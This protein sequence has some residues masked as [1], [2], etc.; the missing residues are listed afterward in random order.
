M[1]QQQSQTRIR[2]SPSVSAKLLM[3]MVG[4]LLA[5]IIFLNLSA[6]LLLKADKRAYTYQAQGT[7]ALLIGRDIVNTATHAIDTLKLSLGAINPD[8]AVTPQQIKAVDLV[9]ANQTGVLAVQLQSVNLETLAVTS[10]AES[11]NAEALQPLEMKPDELEFSDSALRSALPSLKTAGVAFFNASKLGKPA[12]LGIVL[13][14]RKFLDDPHG[15]PI[16]VGYVALNGLGREARAADIAIR[17]RAGETLFDSDPSHQFIQGRVAEDPLF[18]AAW[19]NQLASGTQEFEYKEQRYLG[20]YV[21]PG[22]DLVVL[23]RTTWRKAMAATYALTERFILLG[24]MAIGVAILFGV[25]F[26]KTLTAPINRLFRATQLVGQG[27]FE[28]SLQSESGDEIGELTRSFVAMS[29]RIGELVVEQMRKVQLENELAIASTVQESLIP[30]DRVESKHLT[31]HSHYQSASECGGDWWGYFEVGDKLCLMIAD[32]TGHGLP[33]ALITA[34]ARSCMSVLHKLGQDEAAFTFSPAAMLTY[35]SRAIHESA[36]G[37]IMMTFFAAVIDFENSTMTFSSAGHNPPWLFK[38]KGDKF[39]LKSLVADG[40]RLGEAMDVATP[41]EEKTVPLDADDVL[42]LYTDGL[43][44]G[45]S[46][47]GEQYGKKRTRKMVEANL[48]AG[49]EVMLKELM[50]DFMAFNTD[51]P[52]DDDVTLVATRIHGLRQVEATS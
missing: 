44:E 27:N 24:C 45:K 33:S 52:L 11:T 51:K 19:A 38:K 42:F 20:S 37:K 36:Q 16:A 5:T 9:L 6:I 2:I 15:L 4:L 50:R 46:P 13:A 35:A 41:Y 30:A 26:A 18:D 40:L 34:A 14:D 12:L 7:G 1:G 48:G 49:T 31:I 39:V 8:S 10:M 23:S 3:G 32:A 29:H 17:N 25:L 21:R 47:E 28:V 43:M 22:F